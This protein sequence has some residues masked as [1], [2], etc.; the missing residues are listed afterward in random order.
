MAQVNSSIGTG[1][2]KRI[3]RWYNQYL[4]THGTPP[5]ESMMRAYMQSEIEAQIASADRSR[6]LG[7]E[8]RRID[9]S[10]S[11]FNQSLALQK[12]QMKEQNEA[13]RMSGYTN[14][15][16]VGLMGKEEIK[17][18]YNKLFPGKTIA[19]TTEAVPTGAASKALP[20]GAATPKPS[21]IPST[22][23]ITTTG[24]A[25]TALS[26]TAEGGM[27]ST[28]ETAGA[29]ATAGLSPATTETASGWTGAGWWPAIG[30]TAISLVEK[31]QDEWFEAQ[32]GESAKEFHHVSSE[33]A[34]G[35]LMGL[36]VAG[37]YGAIVGG[38]LG[39]FKGAV[40][41]ESGTVICTELHRQGL[42][43]DETYEA[44]ERFGKK[45]DLDVMVGYHS[46][47]IPLAGL[48]RKSEVVT[49]IIK[50]IALAWAEN[51]AYKEGIT[52]KK[53]LLG[54]LIH[55][56]GV[57]VCRAIGRIKMGGRVWAL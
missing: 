13:A 54:A 23:P 46:W 35:A 24:G 52:K 4:S 9:L 16:L 33:G 1:G 31:P 20:P 15:A 42:I 25:A 40:E 17:S 21:A 41:V 30:A 19:P 18:G 22:A 5:P 43:D 44:D 28:A 56:I 8:E 49:W 10:S 53:N 50:P 2:L 11:Q 6:A 29:G 36:S 7:L 38:I 55:S 47:G 48:M 57:P 45:Q 3:R 14:L 32:I 26:S 12:Q 39:I 51:M 27:G 37:P 34:Q